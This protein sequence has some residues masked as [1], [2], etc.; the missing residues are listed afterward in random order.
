VFALPIQQESSNQ[1]N[2]FGRSSYRHPLSALWQK[3]PHKLQ[4]LEELSFSSSFTFNAE[5]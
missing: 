1:P 4:H 5:F 2:T 3:N